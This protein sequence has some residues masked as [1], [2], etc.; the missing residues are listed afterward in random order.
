MLIARQP[1]TTPPLAEIRE[2]VLDDYRYEAIVRS[3]QQAEQE[4]IAGYQ[5]VV[6]LEPTP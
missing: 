2:R 6:D 3:R 4:D 1:A 5:V